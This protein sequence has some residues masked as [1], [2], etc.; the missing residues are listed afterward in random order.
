MHDIN[1]LASEKT[2][3]GIRFMDLALFALYI[4]V[5]EDLFTFTLSLAGFQTTITDYISQVGFLLVFVLLIIDLFVEK[6]NIAPTMIL[7]VAS[8]V[9]FFISYYKYNS[10][11][12]YI[13]STYITFFTNAVLIFY[14]ATNIKNYEGFFDKMKPFIVFSLIYAVVVY[15]ASNV[16]GVSV[17][18]NIAYAIL[19]ASLASLVIAYREKK[20]M[21]YVYFA[22]FAI[23]LFILGNRGTILILLIFVLSY[24]MMRKGAFD[25]KSLVT[26][27]ILLGI[28]LLFTF[29]VVSNLNLIE[30]LR[31]F[32]ILSDKSFFQDNIRL[33][34]WSDGIKFAIEN[35]LSINGAVFD[36]IFYFMKYAYTHDI[37]F[38]I[39]ETMIAGL[40][41]HN[42]L[43]EL[44]INLGFV[45]G[46]I[47]SIYLIYNILKVLWVHRNRVEF[48]LFVVS[49]GFIQLM[50][51]NSY[52][53]SI[54]FWFMLG[55]IYSIL[56]N[57]SLKEESFSDSQNDATNEGK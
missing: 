41:A 5:I 51:S 11:Q 45:F 40:Y 50:Y 3:S 14:L 23:L 18:M 9:L 42:L 15:V 17:D 22:L 35:P 1:A 54:W 30:E 26:P 29:L 31:L 55:A 7:I 25:I 4:S 38:Y 34:L 10:F 39:D 21:Y 56:K 53:T 43:V 48:I 37:G 6:R 52:I 16:L 28:L 36:R 46:G 27:L 19:P 44:I 20:M 24:T 47:L 13:G 49:I 8:L 33:K 12:S 32:S 2:H 57:E